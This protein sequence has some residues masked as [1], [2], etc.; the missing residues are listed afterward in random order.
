MNPGKYIDKMEDAYKQ[1][2]RENPEQK[3]KSP[4]QKG[5]HP[6]LGTTAFR[7][8]EGIEIYQA[9][10][11]ALKWAISTARWDIQYAVMVLSS[12]RA[13]LRV[14]HL[15]RIKRVYGFLCKFKHFKLRFRVDEPDYSQ[16]P[17]IP[18]YDWKHSIY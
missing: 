12:Y 15:D 10:K 9:L 13:Q 1:Y 6:E 18:D 4:L 7:D 8:D 2:F 5:D 16:V 3:Y 11:G 14:G 17:V